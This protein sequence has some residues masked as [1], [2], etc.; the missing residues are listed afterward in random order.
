MPYF[1]IR[2]SMPGSCWGRY[3]DVRRALSRGAADKRHRE[4]CVV[5]ATRCCESLALD[6]ST[7][8]ATALEA[9]GVEVEICDWL[10]LAPPAHSWRSRET[11]LVWLEGRYAPKSQE[12]AR[13]LLEGPWDLWDLATP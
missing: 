6:K 1:Q 11:F 5:V 4:G 3:Y 2:R 8:L 9:L 7:R 12:F 10:V 13:A